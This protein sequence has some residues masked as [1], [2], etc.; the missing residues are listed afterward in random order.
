MVVVQRPNKIMGKPIL[1]TDVPADNEVVTFDS[2]TGFWNAE[3]GGGSSTPS[4]FIIG[5]LGNDPITDNVVAYA[6][7]F[8]FED[9][10]WT[11]FESSKRFVIP[12]NCTIKNIH[13][14]LDTH[15]GQTNA[16]QYMVRKNGLDTAL[17]VTPTLNTTGD[18]SNAADVDFD[19][20]DLLTI[21]AD[22]TG[23][24]GTLIP[25][26]WSFGVVQR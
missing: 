23:N 3:A 21:K 17:S 20:G 2:A 6:G 8:D 15:T 10:A 5:N 18:F 16:V 25:R 4:K 12:F 24:T 7:V 19:E 1:G 11:T 9:V 13:M 14:Y 22:N 26:S